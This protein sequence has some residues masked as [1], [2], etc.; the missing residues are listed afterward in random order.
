GLVDRHR[1]PKPAAA[2]VA[3]AFADAPFA[4]ERQRT[5]P[6][7]SV[8]V[9]AYNAADTLEDCLAALDRLTYP[10]YEI[11]LVNDG[12]KDRTGEIARAHPR[13]QVIDTPNAGLSGARNVGLAAATGDILAYTDADT[14]AD[15]D[16]LTFL[17]QPFLTSDVVGS[18]GPNVV[19]DDDPPMAQCIAPGPGGPAHVLLDDRI[20]EHVPGCNMAFRR[21]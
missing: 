19:P 1:R 11:I 10:D 5:W 12:S 20:A 13:V 16:W 8:V 2:A 4:A 6:R 14:R 9:C 18:G 3:G 21:D 15:R 7:V 17:V